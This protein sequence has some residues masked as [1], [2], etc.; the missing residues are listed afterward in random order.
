MHQKVDFVFEL[1]KFGATV[2]LLGGADR[3][4][5]MVIGFNWLKPSILEGWYLKLNVCRFSVSE[6]RGIRH[7]SQEVGHKS[8]I[9]EIENLS[10]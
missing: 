1:I 4:R 5:S 6:F 10:F 2:Q 3:R 7:L 9:Q 8:W